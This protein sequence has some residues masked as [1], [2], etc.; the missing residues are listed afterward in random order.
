[1]VLKSQR[2]PVHMTHCFNHVTP[3]SYV[4]QFRI[5]LPESKLAFLYRNSGESNVTP[6]TIVVRSVPWS[7]TCSCDRDQS[8]TTPLDLRANGGPGQEGVFNFH[9]PQ[10]GLE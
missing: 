6:A 5:R 1:M 3:G 7:T 8:D 2:I 4:V 10:V 9:H